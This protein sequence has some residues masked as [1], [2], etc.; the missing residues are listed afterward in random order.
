M[1]ASC[2][3]SHVQQ[4]HTTFVPSFIFMM[5]CQE[6]EREF[7]FLPALPW[8]T[9]YLMSLNL[10]GKIFTIHS[11]FIHSWTSLLRGHK[12]HIKYM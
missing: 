11:R 4:W 10:A 12:M 8:G 6:R 7:M 1:A 9:K 3:C 2:L 5:C